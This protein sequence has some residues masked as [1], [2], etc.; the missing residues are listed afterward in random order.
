[1]AGLLMGY[2]ARLAYGCNIGAY[3][4]GVVSGSLH[5]WGWL[6]FGF[7]GLSVSASLAS[8]LKGRFNR[9]SEQ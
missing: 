6:L 9:R 7:L 5:G 8:R 3:L 4:G 2:G 1:M